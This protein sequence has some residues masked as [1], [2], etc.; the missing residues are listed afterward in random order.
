MQPASLLRDNDRVDAASRTGLRD[1][2]LTTLEQESGKLRAFGVRR[3]ALFG[4]A[5]RGDD[6][7]ASDLDFLVEFE[8]K[9]FRNYM[10]LLAFLERRFGRKV[11]LVL[12]DGIKPRL[13]EA[14]LREAADVPGL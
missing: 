6:A 7:V 11:D 5:V 12:R 9:T 2:V 14:I 8:K 3:L 1:E 10:G 4:S 13:K